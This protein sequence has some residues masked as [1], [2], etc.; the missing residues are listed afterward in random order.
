MK[1]IFQKLPTLNK[2]K[3]NKK[4]QE[5]EDETKRSYKRLINIEMNGNFR[6]TGINLSGWIQEVVMNVKNPFCVS[7]KTN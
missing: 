4:A 7:S 2:S 3:V 6:Y 1:K 5:K